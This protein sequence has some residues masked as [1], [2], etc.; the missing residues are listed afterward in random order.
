MKKNLGITD[1]TI[2]IALAALAAILYLLGVIKGT[3]AIV[4]LIVALILVATSIF[5]FCPLYAILGINTCR[6]KQ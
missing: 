3:L 6:K 1:K 5:N 4:V 2:R